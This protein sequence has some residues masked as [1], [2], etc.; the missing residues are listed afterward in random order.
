MLDIKSKRYLQKY[1]Q[2]LQERVDAGSIV[3]NGLIN[4]RNFLEKI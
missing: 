1:S 3:E 4:Q 2:K